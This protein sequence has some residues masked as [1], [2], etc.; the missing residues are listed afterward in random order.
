MEVNCSSSVYSHWVHVKHAEAISGSRRLY[1]TRVV[2]HDSIYG[3]IGGIHNAC[4]VY[5][6][7]EVD[8]SKQS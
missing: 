7:M 3:S 2:M 8:A 5:D 6:K 1:E 4:L